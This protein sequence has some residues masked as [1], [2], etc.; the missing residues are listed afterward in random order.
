MFRDEIGMGVT[1]NVRVRVSPIRV[2]GKS[3]PKFQTTSY[4]MGVPG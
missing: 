2:T 4:E 3:P 1:Y